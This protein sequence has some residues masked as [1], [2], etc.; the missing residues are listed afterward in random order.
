[1]PLIVVVGGFVLTMMLALFVAIMMSI[2]VDG[3]PFVKLFIM[4]R[5]RGRWNR[6]VA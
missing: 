4:P 2:I 1:M 6:A 3:G 5:G